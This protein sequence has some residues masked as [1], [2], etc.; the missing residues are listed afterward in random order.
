MR[1]EVSREKRG[2]AVCLGMQTSE[3]PRGK[4]NWSFFRVYYYQH[5][6]CLRVCVC[7]RML[8]WRLFLFAR[9]LYV[10]SVLFC[11]LRYKRGRVFY[12]Q[13]QSSFPAS[14][15]GSSPGG[16][17]MTSATSG[18]AVQWMPSLIEAL[19]AQIETWE[20]ELLLLRQGKQCVTHSS[21]SASGSTAS[22]SEAGASVC[23]SGRSSNAKGRNTRRVGIANAED[24]ASFCGTAET[25]VGQQKEAQTVAE[26]I[27][28]LSAMLELHRLHIDHLE[29]LLR[30]VR[31]E[32]LA[33]DDERLEELRDVLDPYVHSNSNM[34]IVVPEEI[35]QDL[36]LQ[37]SL[38]STST[39]PLET[40]A[41]RGCADDGEEE[42]QDTSGASQTAPAASVSPSGDSSGAP[43]TVVNSIGTQVS[44]AD[45]RKR[46]RTRAKTD[47][48]DE[49]VACESTTKA[50]RGRNHCPN[51]LSQGQATMSNASTSAGSGGEGGQEGGGSCCV[52]V[53]VQGIAPWGGGPGL[54]SGSRGGGG[55]AAGGEVTREK[56]DE[57]GA[58]RFMTTRGPLK[59]RGAGEAWGRGTGV[60]RSSAAEVRGVTDESSTIGKVGCHVKLEAGRWPDTRSKAM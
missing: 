35:Y 25:S 52:P 15:S 16:L 44:R 50:S 46:S 26:R 59:G 12:S 18:E 4:A 11:Q 22:S 57:G 24:A 54:P 13:G 27:A 32:E 5:K 41:S 37:E 10:P 55:R 38:P 39:A 58:A 28:Q 47:E 2:G 36:E 21:R 9:R 53:P 49:V 31:R 19:S 7:V 1:S 8:S 60:K 56:S 23:P 17:G 20:G 30:A 40:A 43:V 6:E 42:K 33:G 51:A 14:G 34:V 29:R 48:K 45:M 3:G